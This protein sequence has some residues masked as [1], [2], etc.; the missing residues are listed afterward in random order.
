VGLRS[1]RGRETERRGWRRL[2]GDRRV[3]RSGTR[4]GRIG[5]ARAF[6]GP[7]HRSRMTVA[8]LLAAQLTRLPQLLEAPPAAYPPERLA[9]VEQPRGARGTVKG[10]VVEAG[11]RR[12]IAGAEAVDDTGAQAVADAQG[13]YSLETSPGPRRLTV[14]APGFDNRQIDVVVVEDGAVEARR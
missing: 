6:S 2:R 10:T 4:P 13:R 7:P 11:T 5:H 8:V 12:P 9:R 1:R 3:W 14:S